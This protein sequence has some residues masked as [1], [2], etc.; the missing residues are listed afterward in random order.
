MG[1][2]PRA[3]SSFE[4][5]FRS[6]EPDESATR[7]EEDGSSLTFNRL[8][9]LFVIYI[10]LTFVAQFIKQ[11]IIGDIYPG[12]LSSSSCFLCST[13]FGLSSVHIEVDVL[14]SHM[15]MGFHPPASHRPFTAHQFSR[16][17]PLHPTYTIV[18][19]FIYE[20]KAILLYTK[21]NL[22]IPGSTV[23]KLFSKFPSLSY[24]I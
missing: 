13:R 21:T 12:L 3:V 1:V 15:W 9:H 8:L 14:P 19:Y 11:E 5:D 23:L 22:N 7:G 16:P 4:P 2:I 20:Q 18:V 10:F 6:K 17:Q 24:V